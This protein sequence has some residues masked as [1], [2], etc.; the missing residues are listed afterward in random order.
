MTAASQSVNACH[1]GHSTTTMRNGMSASPANPMTYD[2][3]A[4]K[5]RGCAEFAKWPD[6]RTEA[7]IEMVRHLEDVA[8]VRELTALLAC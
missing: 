3:A 8:S 5:F 7:I 4:D 2:E 1:T 6:N